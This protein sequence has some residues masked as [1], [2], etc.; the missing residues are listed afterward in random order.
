[1]GGI[2]GF[3]VSWIFFKKQGKIDKN[4]SYLIDLYVVRTSLYNLLDVFSGKSHKIN[5]NETNRKKYAEQLYAECKR[6]G[7]TEGPIMDI[8]NSAI[9]HGPIPDE[10]IPETPDADIIAEISGKPNKDIVKIITD[11]FDKKRHQSSCTKCKELAIKI[12][13]YL[14]K[15]KNP[16]Q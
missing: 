8:Y 12:N 1:M 16:Y 7:V 11:M 15:N 10:N 9:S 14:D 13:D 2:A 5:P 3:I 4:I 6:T